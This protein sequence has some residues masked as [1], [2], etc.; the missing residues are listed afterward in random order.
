MRKGSQ[1]SNPFNKS[2]RITV[3]SKLIVED[4]EIGIFAKIYKLS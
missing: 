2:N 1:D 4:L 3:D